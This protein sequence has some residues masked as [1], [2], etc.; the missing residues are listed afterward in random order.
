VGMA[1]AAALTLILPET[2]GQDLRAIPTARR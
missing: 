1:I 2:R